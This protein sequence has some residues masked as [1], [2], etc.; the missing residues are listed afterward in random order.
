MPNILSSS[1]SYFS[2]TFSM[3]NALMTLGQRTCVHI[4]FNHITLSFLSLSIQNYPIFP[5]ISVSDNRFI[6]DKYKWWNTYLHTF[7]V[8]QSQEHSSFSLSHIYYLLSYRRELDNL[9]WLQNSDKK[10]NKIILTFSFMKI[11]DSKAQTL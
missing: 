2:V 10:R 1:K 7:S 11:V 5:I 9:W 6:C 3:W 8:S 4:T